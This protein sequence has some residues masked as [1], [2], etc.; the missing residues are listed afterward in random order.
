MQ[1]QAKYL[2]YK[3]QSR[4]DFE[5][6]PSALDGKSFKNELLKSKFLVQKSVFDEQK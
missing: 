6:E 2:Q 5:Y 1:R 3:S 4:I